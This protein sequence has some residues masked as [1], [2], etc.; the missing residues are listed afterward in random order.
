MSKRKPFGKKSRASKAHPR[1]AGRYA[2]ERKGRSSQMEALEDRRVLSVQFF[3]DN[4]SVPTV[5]RPDVL[6]GNLNGGFEEINLT[7]DDRFN[8]SHIAVSSHGQMAV[9]SN[10]F[11]TTTTGGYPVANFGDTWAD[12]DSVG[13]LF[14]TNLDGASGGVA[15][16]QVNP[17]TAVAG[18]SVVVNTPT[19]GASDDRQALA[20]DSTPTSPFANNIYAIWTR[21]LPGGFTDVLVSRSND[22][23]ATWS[24]PANLNNSYGPDGVLGGGD[25]VGGFN[26]QVHIGV[27]PTGDVYA[28][29]HRQTGFVGGA[30]SLPDGTSGEIVVARSTDGGL[31]FANTATLPFGPGQADISFNRQENAA[32]RFA[33]TRFLTQGSIQPYVLVDP[34][35]PN[36]VYVIAADDPD[37]N[38]GAGNDADIMIAKS[39]DNGATWA[40]STLVS[41][42]GA[43]FQLFPTAAVDR[44]GNIVVT[45]YDN[46]RGLKNSG[47][48]GI[49]GNTDDDF[50]LDT[51]VTYSTD[52]GQTWAPEFHVNDTPFDPDETPV[53]PFKG[54]PT[55]RIGEYFGLDLFGGTAYIGFHGNDLG[56][57]TNAQT[58][59][60]DAFSI[61]GTLIVDGDDAGVT[62]D[63]I[64]LSAVVGAPDFIQISVN[65]SVQYFGLRDSLTGGIFI[66]GQGGN[67]TLTVDFT[68]GNPIPDAG[69]TYNGGNNSTTPGDSLHVIGNGSSKGVYTPS[70]NSNGSG[71][72]V[73]DGQHVI[74]FN[75]LEPVL[76]N[77]FEDF[78]LVTPNS[79]DVITVDSPAAGR[80]RV[81]GTSN[82]VALEELTFFDVVEFT[83]DTATNDASSP[84]DSV[85]FTSNLVATL[86]TRFTVT[87]GAGNDTVDAHLSTNANVPLFLFGGAGND[88]LLG[89]SAADRLE[90]EDGN[91]TLDGNAGSDQMIGGDGSDTAI[92]DPGD[93]S[94]LIEG[95]DG[96]DVLQFNGAAGAEIFTAQANPNN[97]ARLQFLRNL[98]N[99]NMDVAGV[100]QVNVEAL[101]GADSVTVNNLATTEV[102]V[103]NINLEGTVGGAAGDGAADNVFVNGTTNADDVT[104][105][106]SGGVVDVQGLAARTRI[107]IAET[108]D[109]LTLG[110]LDGNDNL[111]AVA[112]VEATIAIT[113]NGD[114]GN[115]TLSADAILNGGAG[116]D[117]LIGGAGNDTLN[118]NAGDDTLV[119]GGG[120]DTYD[121][122]TGRDTILVQG[123]PG[124]DRI[125]VS[126]TAAGT[127]VYTVNGATE[128]DTIILAGGLPTVEEV[129]V[130]AGGGT[131]IM[132]V[133]VVDALVATP[134]ATLLFRVHGGPPDTTD[135]L[136]VNDDGLG[137]LVLYRKGQ[138]D[139][140]G[141][142][143]VGAYAPVVFD[144]IEKLDIT[145]L[146]PVT[147]GTGSDG[148]GR[149]V[150]FKHDPF[151]NNDARLN[152]TFLGSGATINV[153]PT[154]DPGPDLPF[155]V[156]GDQDWYRFVA[157]ET[158]VLDLQVYF[159]HI[160]TLANGR[161]GLPGDGDVDISVTDAAGNL[162]AA[163]TGTAN[164]ERV[165]IP[166][167]RNQTY[168]LRVTGF[169]GAV[170]N[171]NF[172]VINVP[173][174]VPFV[175]DLQA[176]S[177]SGRN[178]D[179]NVTN[180]TTPTFDIYLDA[181]RLQEFTNLGLI[182]D[183]DYDIQVF[184]NGTFLGQATFVSGSRWTYTATAGQLQEGDNNFITAA[185]LIRDRATPQVEGRGEFSLPLKITLDTIAPANPTLLLDPADDSGV[186]GTPTTSTDRIT[187]VTTPRFVGRAEADAIVRLWADGSPISNN[188]IDGSDTF[189][190]LTVAVPLDGNL[191]FPN[192]QWNQGGRFDLNDPALF[193]RD[194][195]RQI[196]ATA[197]DLAGNESARTAPAVLD[198]FVDTQGPQITNVQISGAPG[199]NLFGLKPGNA[200]QGPT[201]LVNSLVI[202]VR[203]LPNRESPS[204][205][206]QAIVASVATSPGGIVLRGDFTGV[207]AISQIIVIN[208]PPA[209]GLPS[210]ASIQLVFA[211]SLP[212][213]RYTLT[214]ND[215]AVVDFPGN[216]LDGESNAQQPLNVP[217]F[218]SGD[219]QPGGD[220]I[221]RF[222]VDSRP[223]IGVY[224]S[225]SA[226]IDINGNLSFDTGN[227]DATNRDIVF[228]MGLPSDR[229]FA[230]NFA[231][232]LAVA[233]SGF[234]KLGAYGFTGGKWRF[235][236]DFNHDGVVDQT[237]ITSLQTDMDGLPFSGQFN[238][239]H[240]GSEIGVFT[241]KTWHLDSNGNNDIDAGD[242]LITGGD[243]RGYPLVGDFDGDGVTD[244]AT[245]SNNTY[246]FDFG[247]DG[248]TGNSQ[249]QLVFGFDG[250]LERP[251]AADMNRDGITDLG[252]F[253]PGRPHS[254]PSTA[255]EWYFLMSTRPAGNP[256][257]TL[258]A[259][260]AN[261]TPVPFAQDVFAQ[262]GDE[263]ALP[264]VGNFD[265]PVTSGPVSGGWIENL[266]KD[267]L[268]RDA[269]VEEW[270]Y[271]THKVNQGT[272]TYQ[273][274]AQS[275]MTS[276]ERRF[277]IINKL[278]QDYLGRDA[279][280]E[281]LRYWTDIWN[282]TGGPEHVQAGIIGSL[283]YYQ[284][285]GGTDVTWVTAL[286]NNILGRG[287]DAQGTAYWTNFI[288][289]H[290]RA[291][292]VLGF[293]QSDEYRGGLVAAWYQQYLGRTA[294]ASGIKYWVSQMSR[295][296]H[297]ED[298]QNG[299]LAS[300][301]YRNK[302]V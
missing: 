106:V 165:D 130:D 65:G 201:P 226:A 61:N 99:I 184:N 203:D 142:V 33:G 83:I 247:V 140:T 241:G 285:A 150:V 266:Y 64:V 223:E 44:F 77:G 234:D 74:S 173:A 206:Y 23:G 213:D 205:L 167:V 5:N 292:V 301:E 242:T 2:I 273:Q 183:L 262:F 244:L 215:T 133:N 50:L 25:D 225:G 6:V 248:L 102:R 146:D 250:V 27:G 95:G 49:P 191:A 171:Y 110:G 197:E 149:L 147:G 90:G 22:Q 3:A 271:W 246:Y 55:T 254:L 276:D 128:T 68:N 131:D 196:T 193:P 277:G 155:N 294:E 31:T 217:S 258:G 118:G 134:A 116:D 158:G 270:T 164:N 145:P 143:T 66:N 157:A 47:V 104:V 151:E 86:L 59:L 84:N 113:L 172:T 229:L 189:Q 91:D 272:A 192:G 52:G 9:S 153:D 81:D 18:A 87:T 259:F 238:A 177:D 34:V 212:D 48:D 180:V 194:G 60:F 124:N 57:T 198:I 111:K 159:E 280:L 182:A 219:G 29:Y 17:T 117:L 290:T 8:T 181:A 239:A 38:H 253:V 230:G 78:T 185:V 156:P 208:N 222:T 82:G 126:Q 114:G 97:S 115:D 209:N 186:T 96:T 43:S 218:P 10:A 85:T 136:I 252:L 15:V 120:N 295:G 80:N 256:V 39:T 170:N 233:A 175:V 4:P 109:R 28:A 138:D 278:Y 35:R 105:T 41:G 123:T 37:N 298:I 199:F 299:I 245:W 14:W 296:L 56:S 195:R 42:P 32:G 1:T 119:G 204:F 122:G 216:R 127:L 176:A 302:L 19:G 75:H 98:G 232:A 211:A 76:V 92:W 20:V 141:S 71:T 228:V 79:L 261:F 24:T 243:M 54:G 263:F 265:P 231:P 152:A 132:R 300:E 103:V 289:T 286:Y 129:A 235:L 163:S 45:W 63:D 12:F 107:F 108:A 240:P 210:T 135:R 221:A 11:S 282:A 144:G 160:G 46:R 161:A 94:D 169:N 40:R 214:I 174:P 178:N 67:D 257:G 274:I 125:D 21:F 148:L 88:T 284:H 249:A 267:V 162:I 100:E 89:G 121:G 16:T 72:V 154:I 283:E 269:T 224:A 237:I 187:N 51:F 190:G 53:S 264:L 168:Y 188:T 251:V 93:G 220:F 207:I 297:Q 166:V 7:V 291:Q 288:K 62:N 137:D 227:A 70:S 268:G 112:G 236:L 30:T 293:V 58:V 179:D 36:T 200:N 281:G 255:A 287:P 260:N 202:S 275:F 73:V 69:V 139:G 26:Q 279:E 101:G 13:R